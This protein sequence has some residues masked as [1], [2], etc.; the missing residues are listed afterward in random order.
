MS[1]IR[2]IVSFKI[3]SSSCGALQSLVVIIIENLFARG[4][5]TFIM[6]LLTHNMLTSCIIKGVTKG[7]P[8]GIQATKIQVKETDFNAD[9]IARMIPRV[10]W[11]ALIAAATEVGYG[12]N[13]PKDL[14]ENYESNEEFLRQA[15]HALLEIEI[16]EGS[17]IC[18]ETGRSFPIKNG[19]PNML[20]NED[21][22]GTS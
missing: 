15:H 8:L 10:E 13:L 1:I 11:P 20:L 14:I 6:K 16:E 18:P 2:K 17:L 3:V 7:Y 21:E 5:Q 12:E 19:I 22:V 4:I 9:F